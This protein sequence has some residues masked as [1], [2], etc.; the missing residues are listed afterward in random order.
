MTSY[1]VRRPRW[2]NNTPLNALRADQEHT[3][4]RSTSGIGV[5]PSTTPPLG[6]WLQH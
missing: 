1:A 5:A 4:I 6:R 3:Q 2:Q